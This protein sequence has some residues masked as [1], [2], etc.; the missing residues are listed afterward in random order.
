MQQQTHINIPVPLIDLVISEK[1]NK[2]FRTYIWLKTICSGKL[3]IDQDVVTKY[4]ADFGYIDDR[5]LWANIEKLKAR[6]WVGYNPESEIYFIRGFGNI[7]TQEGLSGKQRSEFGIKEFGKFDEW[8]FASSM[9]TWIK[10]R[11]AKGSE[12]TMADSKQKSD[13]FPKDD[14]GKPYKAH[15]ISGKLIAERYNRS[16]PWVSVMKKKC[17]KANYMINIH[18]Y[19]DTGVTENMR[20]FLVQSVSHISHKLVGFRGKLYVQLVDHL[21]T[22]NI[23]LTRRRY[24]YRVV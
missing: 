17:R 3:R 12:S 13:D 21:K 5:T 6:N 7:M 24:S 16:E 15:H 20:D 18:R 8:M 2:P 9:E 23:Y 22:M 19:Y 11:K 4:K 10:Q 14:S 1:L